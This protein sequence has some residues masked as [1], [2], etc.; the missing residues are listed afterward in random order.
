MA[1]RTWTG[2][3]SNA[4]ATAGNWSPANVP[5]T[6]DDVVVPITAA[7]GIAGSNQSAITL[8][9]LRVEEG[10]KFDIGSLGAPLEINCSGDF[11]Y[12]GWANFAYFYGLYARGF[13][14]PVHADEPTLIVKAK[15]TSFT[16]SFTI[17]R[18]FTEIQGDTALTTIATLNVSAKNF[19]TK[20]K[21]TGNITTTDVFAFG[22]TIEHFGTHSTSNIGTVRVVGGTIY[23]YATG[24]ASGYIS[25]NGRV[26]HRTAGTI[27]FMSAF[28]G[29]I[30]LR[31]IP[32]SLSV[33]QTWLFSKSTLDLR[34][35]FPITFTSDKQ[36]FN[37]AIIKQIG[38]THV[39]EW[40]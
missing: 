37:G 39:F 8:L 6:G 13:F 26:Y 27:S 38:N 21:L 16:E 9:S 7:Q 23:N 14:S 22:G 4:F 32:G 1:T 28:G 15:S 30:D 35:A 20:V 19:N 2:S 25:R 34:S 36:A 17:L 18:G 24:G 40:H 10:F 12:N 11:H 33:G 5:V 3:V 29:T 31:G